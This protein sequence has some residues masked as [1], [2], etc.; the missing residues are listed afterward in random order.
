MTGVLR[1]GGG[2]I[3]LALRLVA[4]TSDLSSGTRDLAAVDPNDS[5]VA[6]L[7]SGELVDSLTR[8]LGLESTFTDE[9]ELPLPPRDWTGFTASSVTAAGSLG[10][11]KRH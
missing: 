11:L 8:F 7:A 5:G 9:D 2:E 1:E 4:V 10:C 6:D 3:G